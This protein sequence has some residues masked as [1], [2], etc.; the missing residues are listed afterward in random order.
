MTKKK[1]ALVLLCLLAVILHAPLA[2][3]AQTANSYVTPQNPLA[4]SIAITNSTANT[5]LLNCSSSPCSN[6]AIVEA[7]NATLTDT[8]A[9]TVSLYLCTASCPAASYLLGTFSV[10]L[11][12][13]NTAAAAPINLL[14]NAYLGASL[15]IDS[16]GNKY[17]FVPKS[18]YLTVT[19]SS[20]VAS[21]T[22]T[23]TVLG[24]AY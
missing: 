14:S 18:S 4:Q 22:L 11:S 13:G 15:P 20:S 24:G 9:H 5:T 8:S 6:G 2:A 7:I 10:P 16:N 17:L 1:F 21:K 12:S 19:D 23:L 3:Y